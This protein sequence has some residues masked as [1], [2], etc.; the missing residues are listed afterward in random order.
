MTTSSPGTLFRDAVTHSNP[1]KIVGVINAMAA[2]LA[3]N[4]NCKAIYLSGGALSTSEFAIPDLGIFSLPDVIN[5]VTKLTD[6]TQLPLLVDGDTG[7]GGILN[8]AYTVKQLIK[9]GA[10]AVHI[11]DQEWPKR[12]GHRQGKQIV[13]SQAMC[14]KIKSAVD[15]RTDEQFVIMARTDALATEGLPAAIERAQAYVAAG[16]DM[17]FVEAVTELEQYQAFRDGLGQIPILANITEFGKTPLFTAQQLDSVGVD[18]MLFPLTAVRA[19][20]AIA[21][22]VFQTIEQQGSQAQLLDQ[23]QTREELYQLIDYYHYEKLVEQSEG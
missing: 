11:E 20:N 8:C 14:D 3:E 9:A 13:S 18:M 19:M 7:F 17:I 21:L 1:L 10:A 16:A 6:A 4:A 23:M 12:C 2:K 22:K 15:A 5:T